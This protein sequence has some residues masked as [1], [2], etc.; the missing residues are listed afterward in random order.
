MAHPPE[1]CPR[2]HKPRKIHAALCR[3]RVTDIW[4]AEKSLPDHVPKEV[5][6]GA[7]PQ[8]MSHVDIVDIVSKTE[9][10]AMLCKSAESAWI[11][12]K[13]GL[14]EPHRISSLYAELVTRFGATA[15]VAARARPRLL[16]LGDEICRLTSVLVELRCWLVDTAHAC[17]HQ[18]NA[19]STYLIYG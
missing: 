7:L 12:Q 16:G 1:D 3:P 17:L 6:Y 8:P 13:G 18:S 11:C 10:S 4:N 14:P 19:K 15:S 2:L 5:F 9:S